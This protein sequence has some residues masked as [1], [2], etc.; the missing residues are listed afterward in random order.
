MRERKVK[1]G[2]KHEYEFIKSESFRELYDTHND[3]YVSIDFVKCTKCGQEHQD[4]KEIVVA[5][6]GALPE[7]AKKI[8]NS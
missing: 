1:E 4:K 3:R 7:W 2:C 5:I 8:Q 6:N